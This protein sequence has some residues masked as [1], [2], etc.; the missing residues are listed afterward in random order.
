MYAATYNPVQFAAEQ[1][2]G[3]I[4]GAAYLTVAAPAA[5]IGHMFATIL[6]AILWLL[7]A[8]ID[9]SRRMD[10]PTKLALALTAVAFGAMLAPAVT[11]GVVLVVVFA[12]VTKP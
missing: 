2:L 4:T 3:I 9:H 6:P 8:L 12:V 10:K 11:A 5:A 1:T 7:K